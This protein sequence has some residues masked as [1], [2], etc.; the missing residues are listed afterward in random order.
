MSTST[1]QIA[2]IF[3]AILPAELIIAEP[4]AIELK[5]GR[6]VTALTRHIP[7]VVRLSNEEQILQTIMAANQSHIPL[8][9]F[10]TGKNWGL[11]SKLP[12]KADCVLVDLTQMNRIIE[13]NSEFGYALIEPGVTQSQLADYL[14]EHFPDLSLNFTGS[15]GHTSIV[16]N[17]LERGDGVH[18]RIDDLL[19]VR[20]IFGNGK[21]FEVG[22]LWKYVGSEI[23]SHH[24]RYFAGPDLLGL[25][26]QSNFG[27][28]T[29]MAFRL[30]HKPERCHIF[31]GTAQDNYLEQLV[32]LFDYFGR[33]G[34]INRGSVN[35]GYANRFVQAERTLGGQQ[36]QA[37]DL[38]NIWN[39]YVI[40]SG[41]ER[42]TQALITDLVAAFS[43][44]CIVYGS[45]CIGFDKDPYEQLPTFLHPVILPLTGFPDTKS[46]K[47]I[48]DLT[49]TPLPSSPLEMDVDRT[50]FGMKT[51][52][53]VIPLRGKY[54]RQGAQIIAEIRAQFGMNVKFSIFGDGRALITIHF[55]TDDSALVVRAERC[56]AAI[57][58]KMQDAGFLPY[59]V[60]INKMQELIGLQPGLFDIVA[61]LKTIFDPANIIA[62]GRYSS[63]K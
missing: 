16:G 47:L 38:Q 26:S 33:Q 55:R 57:W 44:Y 17:V 40:V 23:P 27:I 37:D 42:T 29:Q 13:V 30:I 52:I 35:I 14:T 36:N 50:P 62:P 59:R 45:H 34:V 48:Y 24:S 22:G 58:N 19:G 8:Y 41:T 2:E 56:E 63:E 25:F 11:G 53:P 61:Q 60:S 21:R 4:E 28:I 3:K 46:I 7:L 54:V 5:Y 18:A 49:S 39:F 12:V 6:N 1:V 15:F 9:P 31:W 43:P 32:D 20:G 10:S 51:C